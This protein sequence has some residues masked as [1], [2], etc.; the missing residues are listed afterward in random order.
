MKPQTLPLLVLALA[1]STIVARA[2]PAGESPEAPIPIKQ[3]PSQE[4]TEFPPASEFDLASYSGKVV[5]QNFWATWCGPCRA[6]V[7]EF[8]DQTGRIAKTYDVP[9]PYDQLAE[10][11]RIF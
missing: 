11:I 7:P 3:L 5:L 4:R 10:D 6:E 9:Q 1:A 8:I 2:A